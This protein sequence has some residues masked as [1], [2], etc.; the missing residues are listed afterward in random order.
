VKTESNPSQVD[1]SKLGQIVGDKN[2][3]GEQESYVKA[4][5]KNIKEFFK[6]KL[7]QY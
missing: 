3:K 6:T 4:Q 1:W 5:R 7:L 2:I